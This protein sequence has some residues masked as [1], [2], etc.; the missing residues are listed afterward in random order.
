[1]TKN[2]NFKSRVRARAA[3]TGESY[4]TARMH[5]SAE[6][7]P[8]DRLVRLAVGQMT[9]HTDPRSERRDVF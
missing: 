7:A 4:A 2:G 1:M 6:Q 5:I 9:I 8:P 3:K